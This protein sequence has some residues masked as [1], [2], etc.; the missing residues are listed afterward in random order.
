MVRAKCK[1]IPDELWRWQTNIVT[2]IFLDYWC[3]ALLT[4]LVTYGSADNVTKEEILEMR[5][6]YPNILVNEQSWDTQVEAQRVADKGL[7]AY[8]VH[9]TVHADT[10]SGP[11]RAMAKHKLECWNTGTN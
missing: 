10:Q 2:T 11:V 4:D 7:R 8:C 9:P 3:S 5:A 6:Q 1:H